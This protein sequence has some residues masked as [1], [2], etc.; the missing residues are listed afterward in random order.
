MRLLCKSDQCLKLGSV[1]IG[2]ICV[3]MRWGLVIGTYFCCRCGPAVS[4]LFPFP[5]FHF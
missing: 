2:R 3:A 5:G 4:G 1:V